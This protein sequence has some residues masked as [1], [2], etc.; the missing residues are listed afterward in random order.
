MYSVLLNCL[1]NWSRRYLE[2]ILLILQMIFLSM[3]MRCGNAHLT[4]NTQNYRESPTLGNEPLQHPVLL[5]IIIFRR[6]WHLPRYATLDVEPYKT[7][8]PIYWSRLVYKNISCSQLLL[9]KVFSNV[10]LY[11]STMWSS[12]MKLHCVSIDLTWL[13]W[14]IL[15]RVELWMM[16][17]CNAQQ[18]S[19]RPGPEATRFR[20]RTMR[21]FWRGHRK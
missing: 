16:G 4:F 7:I 14:S 11:V 18:L 15:T 17:R 10:G 1:W 2:H 3:A 9:H 8:L 12:A 19:S 20:F 13:T 5:V 21:S 6:E